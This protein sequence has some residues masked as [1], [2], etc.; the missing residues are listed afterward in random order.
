MRHKPEILLRLT[1][2]SLDE[3]VALQAAILTHCAPLCKS[4]GTLVY[5]TC[6]LNRKE[7]D[8][9]VA[10]FLLQHPEFKLLAEQTIFPDEGAQDGFYIAKMTR[11]G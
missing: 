5:S 8:K 4:G 10:A 2:D 6:T 3:I 9:Q 1:P 11:R 7:N